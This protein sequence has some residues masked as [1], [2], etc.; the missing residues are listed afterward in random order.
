MESVMLFFFCVNQTDLA[1]LILDNSHNP[2]MF[3]SVQ[4]CY[5]EQ[6]KNRI[7]RSSLEGKLMNTFVLLEIL[8]IAQQYC[9]PFFPPYRVPVQPPP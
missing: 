2:S 5:N 6:T 4:L 7:V 9:I 1:Q 8:F 3:I